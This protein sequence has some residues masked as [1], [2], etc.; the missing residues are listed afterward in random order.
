[1]E[2]LGQVSPQGAID[3][4][5]G[6]VLNSSV[7]ATD[8]RNAISIHGTSLAAL[9]GK[10]RR[11]TSTAARQQAVGPRVTQVQQT[12][13]LDLFFVKQIPFLIGVLSPLGLN[14]C[15]HIKN[16]SFE[17]VDYSVRT[18]LSIAASRDFAVKEVR[19]D[20]EGALAVMVPALQ[21]AGIITNTA[22]PG[23]HVA[24]AEAMIKRVK[25]GCVHSTPRYPT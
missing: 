21:A 7:I 17:C 8:V 13:D 23:E 18:F 19:I 3:I 11:M 12:L 6:G 4:V 1:M 5:N 2:R 9:K 14:L 24:R 20:G 22:G 25:K 16:R 15:Q 10:T